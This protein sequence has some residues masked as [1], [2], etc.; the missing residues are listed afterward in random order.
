MK[1]RSPDFVVYI[2]I[3]LTTFD[4]IHINEIYSEADKLLLVCIRRIDKV[5]MNKILHT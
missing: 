2:P 1:G 3:I 5:K 4:D